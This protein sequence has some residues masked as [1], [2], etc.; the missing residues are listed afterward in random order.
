MQSELIILIMFGIS[1]VVWFEEVVDFIAPVVEKLSG[2]IGRLCKQTIL[3]WR[4][5]TVTQ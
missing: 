4:S 5:Y 3:A 2:M 1:L